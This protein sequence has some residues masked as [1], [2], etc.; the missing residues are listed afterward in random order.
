VEVWD[1]LDYTCL[2]SAEG[3]MGLSGPPHELCLVGE[4]RVEVVGPAFS[5]ASRDPVRRR[6]ASIDDYF[7]RRPD[8]V[9]RPIVVKV[10]VRD[11]RRGRQALLWASGIEGE[12]QCQDVLPDDPLRP[13]LPEGSRRV[14]QANPLP[15]YSPALP[16]RAVHARVSFY[17][18]PEAGQEEVAE[19]DKLLRLAGGDEDHYASHDSFFDLQFHQD[20]SGA[21]LASLIRGLSD[22]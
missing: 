5:A 21:Q 18:C 2:L 14:R 19:A 10:Y 1:T 15:I 4:D 3:S 17:V 20:V 13:H 8:T 22:R 16:G 12:L 6:F 7:R 9:K 11:D